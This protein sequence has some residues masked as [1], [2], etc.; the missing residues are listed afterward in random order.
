[1]DKRG[2]VQLS[3]GMIISVIIIAATIIVAGYVI[4]NFIKT[5]DCAQIGTFY[6]DLQK[7]VDRIYSSDG[8]QDV[9]EGTLPSKVSEVCMGE[10]SQTASSQDKQKQDYFKKYASND[11]NMFIYPIASSC[12]NKYSIQKLDHCKTSEFFCASLVS[13]KI[14]IT[15]SK[16]NDFEAL[17]TLS[18]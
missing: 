9:F 1:M 12:G 10:L 17:A 18:K 3:F 6:Q 2:Q 8:G 11:K 16:K 4:I 5:R 14:K 7:S 13:N 15:I